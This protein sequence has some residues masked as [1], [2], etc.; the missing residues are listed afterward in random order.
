M[1]KNRTIAFV[2]ICVMLTTMILS[3]CG[4]SGQG[5]GNSVSNNTNEITQNNDTSKDQ[6]PVKLTMFMGDAGIKFPTDVDPGDNHIIKIVEEQANVDLEITKPEYMDFQ[7]KFNL[8]MSSGEVL[9]VVHAHFPTEVKKYG[10]EGAFIPL[11]DIIANSPVLSKFHT[12]EALDLT[13]ANDG[14]LYGLFA[15]IEP[16][17][18]NG[19]FVARLDLIDELNGGKI[20]TVPEEWYDLAKKV[21]EKYPDSTPFSSQGNLSFMEMFFTAYGANVESLGIGWQVDNNGKVI[22]GFEA[23][24]MREAVEFYRKLYNDGLIDP[25]FITNKYEDFMMNRIPERNVVCLWGGHWAIHVIMDELIKKGQLSNQLLGYVPLPVGPGIDKIEVSKLRPASATGFHSISISSRCQDKDAAIRTI[26]AFCSPE[27]K[28]ASGWGVE[29][30]E[31]T[32]NGGKEQLDLE[33]SMKNDWRT[34]YGFM[35]QYWYDETLAVKNTNILSQVKDDEY[36]TKFFDIWDK[37]LEINAKRIKEAGIPPFEGMLLSDDINSKVG[38]LKADSLAI[39]LKAI[40]GQISMQE[41]DQQVAN[42]LEKYGY[43]TEAVQEWY[44][45]NR[46]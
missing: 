6:T 18:D 3:G 23:P 38:D 11:D 27:I 26:E 9:D 16:S 17:G 46:K 33:V 28:Y 5:T 20:P 42:Y 25:N 36:K 22:C 44:N 12:E 37:G 35:W 30:T 34:A 8:M 29:G 7:T 1:K 4:N 10:Q 31:F 45:K 2:V 14:K 13:R 19:G 32:K 15:R 24:G 21:K 39:I 40:V 41:Y 43:Y